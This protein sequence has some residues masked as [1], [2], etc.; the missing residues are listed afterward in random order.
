MSFN[1][2]A[3]Y[4]IDWETVGLLALLLG[5][6]L[7]VRVL[8]NA[9]DHNEMRRWLGLR[10]SGNETTVLVALWF[11]SIITLHIVRFTTDLSAWLWALAFV[12]S[13]VF[14]VLKPSVSDRPRQSSDEQKA[15]SKKEQPAGSD[16]TSVET[17]VSTTLGIGMAAALPYSLGLAGWDALIWLIEN[18]RPSL[19][20]VFG[21][22][23][24]S[25]PG[26]AVGA[27]AVLVS[28]AAWLFVSM[29]QK[30][31]AAS[32]AAVGQ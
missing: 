3:G 4:S 17:L 29:R 22:P 12:P 16:A 28:A 9:W 7:V 32:P 31:R 6:S 18:V 26:E 25:I 30:S 5:A 11:L 19:G 24:E 27:V 13:M 23:L 21:F 14:L 2:V 10:S 20:E 8:W 1:D 15:S